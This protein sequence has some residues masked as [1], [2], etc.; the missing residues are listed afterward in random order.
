[1]KKF[2]WRLL[3]VTLLMIVRIAC[4]GFVVKMLWT[5]FIAPTFNT[6]DLGFAKATGVVLTIYLIK[7]LQRI[8][9]GKEEPSTEQKY[10]QSEV[11]MKHV[12]GAGEFIFGQCMFLGIAWLVS[13]FM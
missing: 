2:F 1:M 3:V 5:W 6:I 13:F 9:L 12:D 4:A 11:L 10:T 7:L 8:D